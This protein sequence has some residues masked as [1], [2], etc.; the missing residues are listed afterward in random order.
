MSQK[1][2][3]DGVCGD[4]SVL[5]VGEVSGKVLTNDARDR[6]WRF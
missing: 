3:S 4:V 5:C 6:R 1:S 2:D